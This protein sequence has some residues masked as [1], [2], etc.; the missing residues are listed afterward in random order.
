MVKY[1]FEFLGFEKLAKIPR[2]TKLNPIIEFY[3]TNCPPFSPFL[4]K[5][6]PLAHLSPKDIK[7]LLRYMYRGEANHYWVIFACRSICYLFM[8]DSQNSPVCAGV[9]PAG[10][11]R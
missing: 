10:K 11:F 1:S 8:G 4:I 5:R 6:M 7:I 3:T 2:I 9:H